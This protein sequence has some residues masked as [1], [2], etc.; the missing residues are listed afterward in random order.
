MLGDVFS[1]IEN[2]M[3]QWLRILALLAEA[4]GSTPSILMVGHVHL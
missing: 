2:V 3:A 1:W 4:P